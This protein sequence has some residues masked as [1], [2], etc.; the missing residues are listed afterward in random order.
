M[1]AYIVYMGDKLKDEVS[2]QSDIHAN[3]VEEVVGRYIYIYIYIY[4]LVCVLICNE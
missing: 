1:Q 2:T 4:I 3:M